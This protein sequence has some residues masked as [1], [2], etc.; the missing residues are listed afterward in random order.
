M[1]NEFYDMAW[2]DPAIQTVPRAPSDDNVP[3]IEKSAR[4]QNDATMIYTTS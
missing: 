3:S 4:F 1:I 2:L